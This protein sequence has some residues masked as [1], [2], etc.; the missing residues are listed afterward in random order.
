MELTDLNSIVVIFYFFFANQTKT[1]IPSPHISALLY[2]LSMFVQFSVV[3]LSSSPSVLLQG[4]EITF[5]T[6][7]GS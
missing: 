3:A 7:W 4:C 1:Y 6:A 5:S 2:E